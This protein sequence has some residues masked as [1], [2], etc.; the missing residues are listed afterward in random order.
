MAG[1]HG[2]GQSTGREAGGT[3]KMG[4]TGFSRR[5]A[6]R[7]LGHSRRCPKVVPGGGTG[8]G[9][10]DFSPNNPTN[11]TSVFP[12][13]TGY[14]HAPSAL[15]NSSGSTVANDDH[16][17][18][19]F[20]FP[21]VGSRHLPCPGRGLQ[22]PA[23]F[24]GQGSWLGAQS[25]TPTGSLSQTEQALLSVPLVDIS[26][27]IAYLWIWAGF[28]MVIVAAGLAALDREALEAAH[29]DGATEWQTLRRVT[30]PMLAPV[31]TVVFVT[32]VINVLKIFDIIINLG[33]DS[34]EPGGQASTLASD[35]YYKGFSDGIHTGL[36]SALAVVL[37]L[38]VIPAMLFNLKRI[39]GN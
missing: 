24:A 34:S 10:A 9:L 18:R 14:P 33:A 31:L 17:R 22:F 23:G 20:Q 1:P 3:V 5:H 37:F 16:G 39:R 25:L 2:T 29:V 38:L 21:D 28:T 13:R 11:T 30:I 36:A 19:V 8:L 12:V 4:L 7:R 26:M 6:S 32:M 15:V 35:I 27:I